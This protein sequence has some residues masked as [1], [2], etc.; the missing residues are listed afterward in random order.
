M[1]VRPD[2]YAADSRGTV[3]A[4]AHS[5]AATLV[6]TWWG[7]STVSLELAGIRVATDPVLGRRVA[8]LHRRSAAPPAIA[9]T[10]DVVLV[11][12]LHYDH[13]D[14]PSLMRFAKDTPLVVPTGTAR[15]IPALRRRHLVEVK[16]G[17]TVDVAGLHVEALPAHH[18]GRRHPLSR[19]RVPA[20]GY[21]LSAAGR[22]A[23]YPGDTGLHD[24]LTHLEP[25]DLALVPIGGWG[26]GLGD[27]H[28]DPLQAAEAVARVGARWALAVHYGTFWP[29]GLRRTRPRTY[30]RLFIDPPSRF[31]DAV[32]DQGVPTTP[33]TPPFGQRVDLSFA[34]PTER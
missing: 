2:A 3:A 14:A 29:L 32:R 26:P 7:H 17:D 33:L 12:H 18:D 11:S 1:S 4:V 15:A 8:H 25:V 28:F 21:R 10:A 22:T 31:V 23:W 19:H 9:G 30:R 27:H 24:K 6:A 34:D 16:P 13:L 5:G 20:L